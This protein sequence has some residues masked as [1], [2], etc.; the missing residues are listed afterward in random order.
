MVDIYEKWE[1]LSNRGTC[2][3]Q[4]V[5]KVYTP[6]HLLKLLSS[7]SVHQAYKLMWGTHKSFKL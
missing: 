1:G 7:T 5:N 6:M 4:I 2:L 3:T